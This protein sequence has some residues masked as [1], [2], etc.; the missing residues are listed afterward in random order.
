[1]RDRRLQKC[2]AWLLL[3]FLLAGC[4]GQSAAGGMP[5]TEIEASGAPAD[6]EDTADAADAPEEGADVGVPV[7]GTEHSAAP[8]AL[9]TSPEP[10]APA[11]EAP[12][13]PTLPAGPDLV[14]GPPMPDS[15]FSD[16][17]FFGNSLVRGLELYGGLSE[18][19]FYGVTSASVFNVEKTLD[20]ELSDGTRAT[21]MDA[22][23]EQPHGKIY[24]LLGI[25]EIL[26]DVDFFIRLYN[27]VLNEIALR[28]PEA[29]LYIMSLTPVTAEKD[30]DDTPFT[31]E[32]VLEYNEALYRLAAERG[33]W[34]VDLVAALSDE[35]GFLPAED[36]TD[37]IHL[38]RAKYP[39]WSDWL[40]THY[41]P[42]T[43]VPEAGEADV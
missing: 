21:L 24:I 17:A 29:E 26:S 37:G 42:G 4:G 9:V 11:T 8:N 14:S 5:S 20:A 1:M 12:P 19:S 30:A 33:C 23:C 40:R 28:E 3:F 36:S 13:E 16:A 7:S 43:E 38:T 39:A 35:N 18:A 34:Y 6:A 25:N 22:L 31:R 15:Y 10:P 32:R 41:P 2:I 27:S